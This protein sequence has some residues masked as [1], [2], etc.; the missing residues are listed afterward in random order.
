MAGR[1]IGIKVF[2]E[3]DMLALEA[4]VSNMTKI[5]GKTGK[6]I[7]G[8]MA[9]S[10]KEML[11]LQDAMINATNRAANLE[12]AAS[13]RAADAILANKKAMNA[14]MV[15]ESERTAAQQRAILMAPIADR[16]AAQ[17]Q[18]ESEQA[19]A[20]A[21]KT[22]EEHSAATDTAAASVGALGVANKIGMAS[23]VAL[24]ATMGEST[25]KAG[26]F[27]Q[28]MIKLTASAGESVTNISTVQNGILQMAGKVGYSSLDLANAMYTIEKAGYRGADALKVLNAAAQGAGAEQADLKE[29]V[30]GLTTSMTDF[31]VTPDKATTLMSKMVTAVGEAKTSFQDFAGALHSVEP[32]AAIAHLKLEDV[33]GTLAQMTQSGMGVDQ[34]SQNMNQAITSLSRPNAA[35]SSKMQQLG[36]NPDDISQHL[37]D[38][39]LA[40]TMQQMYGQIGAKVDPSTKLVDTGQLAHLSGGLQNLHSM[41]DMSGAGAMSDSA[42]A[43]SKAY[44]DGAMSAQAY[45]KEI[46]AANDEDKKKMQQFGELTDAVNGF[47]KKLAGGRSTLETMNAALGDV[48]GTMEA[49]NVAYQVTGDN[50][51]KVNARIAAIANTYTNADGTVKGF[52]ESQE[53]L[54]AKLRDSRAAF[55]AASTEIGYAFI[56]IMTGAAD[57]AKAVGDELA[58]HPAIAQ[59]VVVAVGAMGTAWLFVKGIGIAKALGEVATSLIAV[60]AGED[61][62]AAAAARMGAAMALALP[63]LTAVTTALALF[64]L[65]GDAP[66]AK[67]TPQNVA[68]GKA[69]EDYSNTHGGSKGH[70]VWPKG[71]EQWLQG[72]GPQ[73][74]DLNPYY[75]PPMP[76]L[77]GFG[78]HWDKAQGWVDDGPDGPPAPATPDT[79][80]MPDATAPDTTPTG[81]VGGAGGPGGG[82][83]GKKSDADI[84]KALADLG[85][86]PTGTEADPMYVTQTNEGKSSGTANNPMAAF[87]H[88]DGLW[89]KNGLF[90]DAAGLMTTFLGELA[91]GNPLGKMMT[92]QVSQYAW[93]AG[94]GKNGTAN[95]KAAIS[96]DKVANAFDKLRETLG[97][98]DEDSPEARI[99]VRNYK[100]AQMEAQMSGAK[101]GRGQRLMGDLGLGGLGSIGG[102][103]FG[104]GAGKPTVPPPDEN[105][106]RSW[107][108]SKFGIPN[109]MGTG[110]WE[111]AAHE[112]D[113]M[114]HHNLT[115]DKSQPGYAF[116]FHGSDQQMDALANWVSQN[117]ADKTLELIHQGTGFDPSG[118][119]KN[120]KRYNYGSDLNSQHGDGPNGHVHWAMTAPPYAQGA[121]QGHSTGTP[122]I[123]PG[124]S[125]NKDDHLAMLPNGQPIGLAGGEAILNS[126]AARALGPAYINALNAAGGNARMGF[127]TGTPLIGSGSGSGASTGNLLM[128]GQDGITIGPG[129]N[130]PAPPPPPPK[131]PAPP[132]GSPMGPQ[133][134]QGETPSQNPA[135][136]GA[137]QPGAGISGGIIGAAEGAAAGAADAFAPGSGAAVQLAAQE[138][139]RA[140][141]WA[142]E[143]ASTFV[144]E[145]PLETFGLTGTDLS[146]RSVNLSQSLPG[147]L[148]GGLAG[149]H[150]NL[151]NTAGDPMNSTQGGQRQSQGSQGGSVHNGNFMGVN[152]E[153]QTFTGN[154]N[155]DDV[156]RGIE[157]H[158]LANG[159]QTFNRTTSVP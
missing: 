17:A 37:G 76:K 97:K 5:F 63:A 11:S 113:G 7:S 57:V 80:P 20:R 36:I 109:S 34:A 39:G 139:N 144:G 29:V 88:P 71:S 110:S 43:S 112:A 98:Y 121:V 47:S 116:D 154:Q 126:A 51:D 30:D 44:L 122:Q 128:T 85:I 127:D 33:W 118:E 46:K 22:S 148:I 83:G 56:P 94:D 50:A 105:T 117:Y 26:D 72:K 35:Q 138:A 12:I 143:A 65:H 142:G 133:G 101:G 89:G 79:I 92:G 10:E 107:V 153:N 48:T 100:D 31:G 135:H 49:A 131:P 155:A 3:L 55:G 111:N 136:T 129:G 23:F 78:K 115:H 24:G 99:A 106:I 6:E 69:L 86:G 21:A 62:A 18:K 145:F 75:H 52:N 64:S 4:V 42:K 2:P 104:A 147:K 84:D 45:R 93:W 91:L 74:H 32:A 87:T 102:N 40:G 149:A 90:G 151:P 108:Q 95:D 158:T 140:I 59:A 120:G 38:R 54:N 15:E 67:A 61:A 134:P 137:K 96:A 146:G 53:G 70:E 159:G 152:I 156:N 132:G 68:Q 125:S 77:P 119:I 16:R 103:D 9:G 124:A 19:S 58:K 8:I 81:D 1:G 13:K 82:K 25:K 123:V 141:Q 66:G 150:P 130:K 114:W 14:A 27:Q 157:Q 41:L 73:P 28:A 60:T